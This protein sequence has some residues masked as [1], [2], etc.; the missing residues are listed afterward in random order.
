MLISPSG[1][2][3]KVSLGLQCLSA[4]ILEEMEDIFPV[5]WIWRVWIG[6]WNVRGFMKFH[7]CQSLSDIEWS[8]SSKSRPTCA[9][10]GASERNWSALNK[11]WGGKPRIERHLNCHR[12]RAIKPDRDLSPLSLSGFVVIEGNR[13]EWLIWKCCSQAIRVRWLDLYSDLAPWFETKHSR[14]FH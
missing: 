3:L 10:S 14:W 4:P 7:R 8:T 11:G 13:G 1:F 6:T 2:V 9:G 12:F 5:V